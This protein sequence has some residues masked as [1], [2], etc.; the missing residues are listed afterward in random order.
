MTLLY[1]LAITLML[2]GVLT[3]AGGNANSLRTPYPIGK[4]GLFPIF[5]KT[6]DMSQSHAADYIVDEQCVPFA[7]TVEE[8]EFCADALTEAVGVTVNVQDDSGTPKVVIADA[9]VAAITAGA[10]AR[11]ALTV[12][13]SKV[14]YDGA[15][16]QFSYISGAGDSATNAQIRLWVKP[17]YGD[18]HA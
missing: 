16:L 11:Q 13:K 9:G 1:I 8:A 18:N 10:S 6:F 7:F 17:Y 14:I 4:K 2:A 15:L 5:S 12:D 3:M